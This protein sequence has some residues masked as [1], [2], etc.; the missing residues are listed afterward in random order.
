[1]REARREAASPIH[2]Q[3][4]F[5][6]MEVLAATVIA[7]IAIVGLAYT[8]GM[9]QSF[10]QRFETGRSALAVAEGRL[11]LLGVLPASSPDLTLGDHPASPLPFQADGTTVGTETWRVDTYDDPGTSFMTDDL[12]KVTVTVTWRFGSTQDSLRLSR[13]MP[14]R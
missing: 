13:L 6:L 5:S 3:G 12:K 1:V 14:N 10:I 4:G 9:G 2:S 7:T 8:F 11:D